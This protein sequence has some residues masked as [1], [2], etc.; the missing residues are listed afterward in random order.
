[1]RILVCDDEREV[2]QIVAELARREGMEAEVV[3]S[4]PA[5][6]AAL[7][8]ADFDLVVLDIMMPGM[9]GYEVCRRIRSTSD[10]PVLFLSAKNEE[11]DQVLGLELGADDYVTKPFRPRELMARV[12][13]RA[14]ARRGGSAPAAR[15]GL[16]Q[17]DGL[18][19]DTLAH[20]ATLAGEPLTLTPTEFDLLAELMRH[21]GSPVGARELYEHVWGDGFNASARNSVMVYLRHLRKKL[22]AIDSSRPFIDTVW[23][24]GYRMPV[25]GGRG[26]SMETVSGDAA[27]S[28]TRYGSGDTKGGHDA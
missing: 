11:F 12:K 24:V 15:A 28:N 5:A 10:V 22:G 3:T 18:V 9:D 21:A 1:M 8:R 23:G 20:E 19:L 17:V 26:T 25:R 7:D 27:Y 2:A 6:L 14:R 13:L 4:G 16:L